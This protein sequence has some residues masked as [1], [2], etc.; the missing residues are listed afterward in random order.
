MS[1]PWH[2][3]KPH[4]L[5]QLA[6]P[7]FTGS[8]QG[9]HGCILQ[10]PYMINPI[11]AQSHGIWWCVNY[12]EHI[13]STLRHGRHDELLTD[14]VVVQVY[15]QPLQLGQ[16]SRR[17]NELRTY[18]ASSTELHAALSWWHFEEDINNNLKAKLPM[19]LIS[20]WLLTLLSGLHPLMNKSHSAESPKSIMVLVT[21]VLTP[22]PSILVLV[23]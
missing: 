17:S 20:I 21:L 15:K 9:D 8:S 22:Q 11:G 12:H 1:T 3:F 19:T 13:C 18:L 16:I 10:S 23:W 4:V 2:H 7:C 5:K 6:P 14:V